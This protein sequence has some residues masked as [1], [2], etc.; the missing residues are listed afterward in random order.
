MSADNGIYILKTEGPEYRVAHLQA[1]ENVNWDHSKNDYTDD[2]DVMIQNAREM[3]SPCQP[4]N[5][6]AEAL[7]IASHMLQREFI[8]EYGI[9]SIEIPRVF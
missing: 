3:W 9:C 7:K 8:C 6:E 2:P 5:S 1:V 4:F